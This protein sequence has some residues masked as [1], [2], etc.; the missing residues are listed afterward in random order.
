LGRQER[1][2]GISIGCAGEKEMNMIA[3][4]SQRKTEERERDL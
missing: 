2:R 3:M 1:E 4:L